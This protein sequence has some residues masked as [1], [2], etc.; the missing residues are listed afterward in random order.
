MPSHNNAAAATIAAKTFPPCASNC[1]APA[2]LVAAAV[3]AVVAALLML[4]MAELKLLD[5]LASEELMLDDTDAGTCV[6]LPVAAW[7]PLLEAVL[8]QTAA[9]CVRVTPAESQ[10]FFAYL[11]V[12]ASC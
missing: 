6:L 11:S 1:S 10:I 7:V 4:E 3:A 12:A 5:A 8:A 9:V 2:L